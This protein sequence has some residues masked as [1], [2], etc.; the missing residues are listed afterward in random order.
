MSGED[1]ERAFERL[2]RLS[3]EMPLAIKTTE[4]M[5][6]RRFVLQKRKQDHWLR[7]TARTQLSCILENPL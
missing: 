6:Y 7:S 2:Y 3:Q 1:Y 4:A 5:H